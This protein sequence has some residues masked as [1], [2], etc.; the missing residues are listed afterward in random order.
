M[1]EGDVE[2][3]V[4]GAGV[5]GLS[6]AYSLARRGRAVIVCE[7][8]VVGHAGGGSKGSARIFRLGYDDPGYVRLA[9][10]AQR[11]WRR[12]EAE[13]ATT[14]VTRTGQVTF[15]DD[16]DV[17]VEAMSTSGAPHEK[18][19]APEVGVRFPTLS[20]STGAVF[21]PESGVI[22]ADDCLVALREMSGIEV[23]ERTRVVG[24]DDDGRRVTVTVE[25]AE[26]RDELRAT[27]VVVCGGPWTTTLVSDLGVDLG[28]EATLEQVAYLAPMGGPEGAVDGLPVFVERRR[29][30]FYGLPV[31]SRGVMKISLHGAGP[32]VS[33]QDL[34]E[35]GDHDRPDDVL[36]AALLASAR[37]V[38]PGL[39]PE[40]MTTERCIYDNSPDGNFVVDRFGRVVIGA[41]T[42][43]HG[44][45]FAPLLGEVLADLATGVPHREDLGSPDDLQRFRSGR[46]GARRGRGRIVHP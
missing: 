11:L 41:G 19:S 12:L 6:A 31:A 28:A 37:R 25:T 1:S 32:V 27:A 5:L 18:L 21:E 38:L 7:Q 45:K 24:L 23:R 43:G 3:V 36:L 8:G 14:L 46:R 16:L 2:F 33:L 44:F 17:L 42:S 9:L 29:P 22:A 20:V 39:A 15:G 10:V 26:K 4:V 40:P 35:G 30:W 13:S 34:A